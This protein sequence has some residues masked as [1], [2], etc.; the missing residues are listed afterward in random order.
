M[1]VRDHISSN[2]W[3]DLSLTNSDPVAHNLTLLGTA[4]HDNDATRVSPVIIR[5]EKASLP[6]G[7]AASLITQQLSDVQFMER[8]DIVRV[9][10]LSE[11]R[12]LAHYHPPVV[13]MAAGL[14]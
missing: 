1:K 2:L 3:R 12:R 5:V 6:A 9:L 4:A 8:N 10:V 7:I 11:A 13:H 14:A